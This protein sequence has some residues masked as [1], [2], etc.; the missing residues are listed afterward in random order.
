MSTQLLSQPHAPSERS[1]SVPLVRTT[2][3][4]I[5]AFGFVILLCF[6][7]RIYHLG[8]ASLWSDE[9]FSRYYPDV[10]G[11]HFLLTDGMSSEPTRPPTISCFVVG[12]RCGVIVKPRSAHS[13]PWPA[14][15]ACQ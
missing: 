1:V 8:V 4:E 14:F 5:L 10:F 7:L 15:F 11:L 3:F 6:A 2:S 9:F 13:P 12:P